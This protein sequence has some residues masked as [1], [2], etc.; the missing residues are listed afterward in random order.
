MAKSRNKVHLSPQLKLGVGRGYS[1]N[2]I[3]KYSGFSFLFLSLLL[4]GWI[5]SVV[6]KHS[7]QVAQ[8]NSA[9]PQVLGATDNK[10]DPFLTYTV[11][12]GDTVFNIAQKY[13]LNWAT[14]ATINNLASP[15]TLKPG[16]TLKI[17]N[18]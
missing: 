5:I 11:Q 16:Q 3:L 12:K 17:P 1:K 18:Q 4:F 10:A 15:F 14:L 8:N 6:A 2:N 9:N 7:S 13:N